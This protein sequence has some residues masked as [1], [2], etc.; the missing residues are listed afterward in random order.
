MDL[1]VVLVEA[2]KEVLKDSNLVEKSLNL[3][4]DRNRDQDHRLRKILVQEGFS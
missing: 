1:I 2:H 3:D 4:L